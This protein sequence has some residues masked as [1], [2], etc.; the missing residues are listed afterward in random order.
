MQPATVTVMVASRTKVIN[1]RI[2]RSRFFGKSRARVRLGPRGFQVN[3]AH[4]TAGF[5]P[6]TVVR[7]NSH[8][9]KEFHG[10]RDN[11]T[12]HE[13]KFIDKPLTGMHALPRMMCRAVRRPERSIITPV[14]VRSWCR[15]HPGFP[16]MSCGRTAPTSGKGT[17]RR[18]IGYC[19]PHLRSASRTNS[20]TARRAAPELSSLGSA[21]SLERTKAQRPS[22][23]NA[24]MTLCLPAS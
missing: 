10:R 9:I 5:R 19:Q 2:R 16:I 4:H 15:R 12:L 8:L 14:S 6:W 17:A 23:L 13:T 11:V 22:R 7:H 18:P 20:A 21:R 24:A 1:R 3:L